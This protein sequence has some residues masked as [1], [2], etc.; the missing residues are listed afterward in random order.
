MKKLNTSK[1]ADPNY[2]ATVI[3]LPE[4]KDHPNADKLN[5]VEVF[6]N[7]IVIAKNTYTEGELVVYFPVESCLSLKFLS[8]AN[9]IDDPL[10]N[11]DAKTRG[12]FKKNGRVRAVSLRSIPSQGFLFKV[13]EL[14]KYYNVKDDIFQIGKD[15]DSVGDDI[16]VK[17]YVR[18]E[19]TPNNK[20]KRKN[21]LF[22]NLVYYLPKPVKTKLYDLARKDTFSS[23]IL[24][25]QFHFHYKTEQLGKNLFLLNPEDDIAITAKF[26]GTSAIYSNILCKPQ[27][28]MLQKTLR[29]LGKKYPEQE[30]RFIYSSRSI[31]KN[32]KDGK[33]T[34]DVWGKWASKLEGKIPEGYTVYGEIVG[35]ASPMKHVQ[36][37]YDYGAELGE[38]D[39]YV[40]RVTKVDADGKLY[41]LDWNEI[42]EFCNT[43]DLDNVPV[44]YQG[45]AENLFDIK[46]DDEWRQNF[47]SVLKEKYLDKTCEF[48]NTGV[49]NEGIVIKVNNKPSRPVYKFKSPKFLEQETNQRDAGEANMEEES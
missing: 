43:H 16:L 45:F 9:L 11:S 44:Y 36:K 6:G 25:N 1:D 21:S 20:K 2:L 46:V 3:K 15:F 17:K 40:Y 30:Y 24:P 31:I 27:L 39:F 32:R 34:E 29:L 42:F 47:L 22:W 10:L 7:T 12:F 38:S 4:I 48:C 41:E 37:G 23:I 19:H 13:S 49:I 14:A 5:L 33:Y 18:E 35:Y 8:W 26:H 28:N